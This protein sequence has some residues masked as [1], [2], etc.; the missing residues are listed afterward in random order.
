MRSDRYHLIDRDLDLEV[1]VQQVE[2][3]PDALGTAP[4]DDRRPAGKRTVQDPDRGAGFEPPAV[5]VTLLTVKMGLKT[6]KRCRSRLTIAR[7]TCFGFTCATV[8]MD[9]VPFGK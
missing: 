3:E 9:A 6:V 2:Q 7:S 1:A 8:H 5:L 4:G